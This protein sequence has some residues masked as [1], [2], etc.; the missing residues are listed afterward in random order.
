MKLISAAFVVLLVA[1][2]WNGDFQ[3]ALARPLSLFRDGPDGT[4]GDWLFGLLLL[5]GVWLIQLLLRL[6]YYL[7]ALAVLALSGLLWETAGTPSR[8]LYHLFVALLLLFAVWG[9]YGWLFHRCESAWLWVHLVAPVLLIFITRVHSYG[10]W[11]K[12]LIL[13]FVFLL[14]VQ[15]H[16]FADWLPRRR[17]GRPPSTPARPRSRDPE[18]RQTVYRLDAD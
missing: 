1:V 18:R 7:D 13:Y 5:A 3:T 9:Y 11:Q 15:Y 6:H 17:D 10:L 2:H 16:V 4:A 8:D 12:S 14:N